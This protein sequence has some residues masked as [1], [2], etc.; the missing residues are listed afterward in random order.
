MSSSPQFIVECGWF[1]VNKIG[2]IHEP[3]MHGGMQPPEK[4]GAERRRWGCGRTQGAPAS[5]PPSPGRFLDGHGPYPRW[6]S[7]QVNCVGGLLF[8][9]PLC[10]F[11]LR[12]L[13]V[14]F[15]LVLF[16]FHL[17]SNVCP[18]KHVLSNTS[19]NMSIVYAYVSKVCL[20]LLFWTIIGG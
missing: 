4:S 20:F 2:N 10:I 8:L 9:F 15:C 5:R 3:P 1:G 13:F 6:Y 11:A 19:G 14:P 16:I 7:T 17:Y 12:L 18:A